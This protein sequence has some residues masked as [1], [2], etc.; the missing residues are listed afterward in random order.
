MLLFDLLLLFVGFGWVAN[1]PNESLAYILYDA[2]YDVWLGNNRGNEHSRKQK[3]REQKSS[4]ESSSSPS[5]VGDFWDFSFD[6]MID[7]DWPDVIAY[8]LEVTG[9]TSLGYVGHSQGT[10][11]AFGGLT[12][13][14]TT[15]SVA[16]FGALAPVAYTS[17]IKGAIRLL[18]DLGVDRVLAAA[19]ARGFL[20]HDRVI[21]TVVPLLCDSINEKDCPLLMDQI[22]GPSTHTNASRFGLYLSATPSG[23]SVKNIRHFGQGVRD[24]TFA[25]YDYGP[26]HNLRRYG[27]TTPPPYDLASIVKKSQTRI[28]LFSGGADYLATPTDVKRLAS[29]LKG[30]SNRVITHFVEPSFAHVDFTWSPAA[31]TLV[32]R[33]LLNELRRYLPPLPKRGSSNN[34]RR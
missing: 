25:R 23:T 34:N 4:E 17:H 8:I 24:S 20:D 33:P 12:T 10:M 31:A 6:E 32:Y 14:T 26:V 22:C 30:S 7:Y 29:E 15:D 16:F 2:G 11:Q 18:C 27:T 5:S 9:Q 3:H 21:N 13:T 19:G 28:A 1:L